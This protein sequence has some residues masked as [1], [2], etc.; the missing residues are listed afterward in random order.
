M[1]NFIKFVI[2]LG[3]DGL[4]GGGGEMDGLDE[5]NNGGYGGRNDQGNDGGNA[6]GNGGYAGGTDGGYYY[7]G[8]GD[9]AGRY[10]DRNDEG[11]SDGTVLIF[12]FMFYFLMFIF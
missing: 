10:G 5:V 11:Y 6:G 12:L 1:I 3:G 2:L 8:Y 4:D 9:E 7:G